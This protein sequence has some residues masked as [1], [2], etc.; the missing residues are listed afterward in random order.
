[1]ARQHRQA[2]WHGL[3]RTLQLYG[4]WLNRCDGLVI[5]C[6]GMRSV[7]FHEV[8][9]G[10]SLRQVVGNVTKRWVSSTVIQKNKKRIPSCRITESV[11]YTTKSTVLAVRSAAESL[12]P[13]SLPRASNVNVHMAS[14]GIVRV[15]MNTVGCSPGCGGWELLHTI[16]CEKYFGLDKRRQYR[17]DLH[18]VKHRKNV[19][20]SDNLLEQWQPELKSCLT[21]G[22]RSLAFAA[23]V[24]KT[25]EK[26][27][28]GALTLRVVANLM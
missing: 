9:N 10:Y 2:S 15:D 27:W 5:R 8:C 1:M 23:P 6:D 17:G 25:A 7:W 20:L 22:S 11:D 12:H 18:H 28:V 4:F 19:E 3:S 16:R 26:F 21:T 14:A 24:S 13:V